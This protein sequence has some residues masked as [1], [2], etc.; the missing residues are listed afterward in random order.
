MVILIPSVFSFRVLVPPPQLLTNSSSSKP[1]AATYIPFIDYVL[2][3]KD[4]RGW[5][6][7]I[8]KLIPHFMIWPWFKKFK[9]EKD[10]ISSD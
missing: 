4:A 9:W 8:D 1:E 3:M 7:R 10:S 5:W 2:S 6:L